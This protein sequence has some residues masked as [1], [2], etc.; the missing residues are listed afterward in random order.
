MFRVQKTLLAEFEEIYEPVLVENPFTLVDSRGIGLRQYHVALTSSR[1]I[2]GCDNFFKHGQAGSVSSSYGNGLDPEI[3]CFELVSLIPLKLIRFNFYRYLDRCLMM[4]SVNKHLQLIPPLSQERPM[5]L[6][7]GGYIFKS[8]FWRTW[9]ERVST[10][11]VMQPLYSQITGHSPFSSTDVVVDDEETVALI[12]KAPR[13]P[14][15]MSRCQA[16]S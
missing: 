2:F 13:T 1:I 7:F 5:I 12:H 16:G 4:V 11:R 14:S 8:Y 15:V 6:E 9:R 10:I 3:E